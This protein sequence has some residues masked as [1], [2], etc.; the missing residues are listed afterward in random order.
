MYRLTPYLTLSAALTLTTL[1]GA[2][3]KTAGERGRDAVRGLPA[4]NPP[5]WS[6]KAFDEVWKQWSAKERP[7]DYDAA[8]RERYGLHA[9]PYD[10]RGLPMGLHHARGPGKGITT[11]CLMCHAGTVAGQT[12]LGLSNSTL[13]MQGLFDEL[14]AAD[15]SPFT[16]P[17]QSSLVRGTI[18]PVSPVVFLMGFRNADLSVR[19]PVELD[20]MRELASDPPAWWLLKKKKTRNWNGSLDSRSARVDMATLLH[21]FNSAEFIKKQ[22]GVFADMH[23][24][25]LS[26]QA[27]AYPF[28]I[29]RP[30]AAQGSKV[31]T[32]TC[33][34]C[35]G[36][37]GPE[38]SYPNKVVPLASLGTDPRL[39]ESLTKKLLD[40]FNA[41]WLAQ[42]KGP[43]GTVYRIE[44]SQG[45]QAP[46]LDGV[47]ATAPYFHNGSAPT[48]HHVLNSKARPK[49]FTRSYRTDKDEYD[50]VKLGWKIKV[51]DRPPGVNVPGVER[52]RT[53]DSTRP[54]LSNGGHTYGDK[55][56]EQERLAVIEYLKTL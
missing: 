19:A 39:A 18:N 50:T 20:R 53:Y 11:D 27:P 10:N 24:F 38:G 17:F 36:T 55:L 4:L 56:S 30:L 28:A 48:V 21:P 9:A 7:K 31:Y 6:L 35:H 13:D 12:I 54:G 43:D 44:E 8:F 46:P 47:W 15:G 41:S 2:A 23:A 14:G 3:D 37:H 51:V 42:E 26:V 45:Y 25:V 29:D 22:E 32:D 40:N 33:A 52:R 5:T 1:G 49:F 16:L 34:R